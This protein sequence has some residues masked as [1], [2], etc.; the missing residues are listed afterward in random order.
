[1]KCAYFASALVAMVMCGCATTTKIDFEDLS[2]VTETT[3]GGPPVTLGKPYQVGTIFVEH[4]S[5]VQMVVL[6]FQLSDKVTWTDEGSVQIVPSNKAGGSGNEM[7]FKSASLGIV[8]PHDKPIKSISA[9][10]AKSGGNV[11][12]IENGMLHNH[13]DFTK[14]PSPTATG[15]EIVITP[16]DPFLGTIQ[17]SGKMGKFYYLFPNPSAPG[18]PHPK[19]SPSNQYSAVVGGGSELWIDDIEIVFSQ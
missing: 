16:G 11:N 5:G 7:F 9:K 12:A 1:M 14:V 15:L 19:I 4:K 3:P 18:Q 10:F 6:P 8:S 13:P 2:S 17:L